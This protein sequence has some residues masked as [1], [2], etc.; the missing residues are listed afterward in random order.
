MAI[1]TNGAAQWW[2]RY[3]YGSKREKVKIGAFPAVC[4]ADASKEHQRQ[5]EGTKKGGTPRM[6]QEEA[7]AAEAAASLAR[8]RRMSAELEGQQQQKSGSNGGFSI[9]NKNKGPR[10]IA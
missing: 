3:Q 7:A 9:D 10:R 8:H 5:C 6:Q 4:L 2:H 1:R